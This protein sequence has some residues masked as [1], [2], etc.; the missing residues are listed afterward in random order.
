ML[1]HL[2]PFHQQTLCQDNWIQSTYWRFGRTLTYWHYFKLCD[3]SLHTDTIFSHVAS[4]YTLMSSIFKVYCNIRILYIPR[5]SKRVY[6]NLTKLFAHFLFMSRL[7]HGC[8]IH[9]WFNHSFVH[10][11]SLKRIFIDVT[12]S[13]AYV[14]RTLHD[15]FA[16]VKIVF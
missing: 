1:K 3:S 2:N 8:M 9:S 16:F 11:W 12:T 5:S 14:N 6:L 13:H 7:L 4:F 10:L 15:T